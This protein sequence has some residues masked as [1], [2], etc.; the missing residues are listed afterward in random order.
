MMSHAVLPVHR[1]RVETFE[2]IFKAPVARVLAVMNEAGEDLVD[3]TP[4]VAIDLRGVGYRRAHVPV[5]MQDPFGSGALVTAMCNVTVECAVPRGRRGVHVSRLGDAIARSALESYTGV[6][7]YAREL[8]LAISRSQRDEPA[9][10]A[11][12]ASIP[13]VEEVA[14]ETGSQPKSSLEDL[15]L[16]AKARVR[17]ARVRIDSGIRFTHIV[18]CP[19]VQKTG[20][21]A[22]AAS[23]DRGSAAL[24]AG[25]AFTHTQRCTTTVTVCGLAEPL[26]VR[27][28]LSALD[29]VVVRTMSTLPRGAE[30]AMVYRAHRSP[31]FIEDAVR[32]TLWAVYTALDPVA[33][34]DRVRAR[35]CSRESIH[36]FDLTASGL[37]TREA[38]IRCTRALAAGCDGDAT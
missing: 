25:P 29:R 10:V 8:A 3:A 19:C 12:R 30:L 2:A 26:P 5:S 18:A 36:A 11:V 31:Q 34:F 4:R 37:L 22:R 1:R 15:V 17:H 35:S 23:L 20:E 21:H 27:D 9:T 28:I 32:E 7:A 33:P 24:D 38:A 14:L 6:S 13:Y 16:V